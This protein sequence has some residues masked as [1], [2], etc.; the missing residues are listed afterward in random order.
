[1]ILA[2]FTTRQKGVAA[3][4]GLTLG[5]AFLAL[6]YRY[7]SSYYTAYQQLYSCF[8]IAFIISF[9]IFPQTLSWQ[10]LKQI[11]ARD[12]AIM[13]VRALVYYVLAINLYREA[14]TLTKIGNV[15]VMQAVPFTALFGMLFFKEKVTLAKAG[16][17][18]FA[19]IGVL[20]VVVKDVS[21][22]VFGRGEVLALIAAILFAFGY[23]FRKWQTTYLSDTEIT[24][25]ILGLST[26]F[27]IV[28][29]LF[30][31]GGLQGF[32]VAF[33]P[34]VILFVTAL[35][36]VVDIFFINYGFNNVPV[37]TANNILNLELVF[38]L[39]L[40]FIFYRE[41][42]TLLELGGCV[43][44]VTSAIALSMVNHT[45]IVGSSGGDENVQLFK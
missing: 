28:S 45:N 9:F 3:L 25:I 34:V 19:F 20:M 24:Q 6:T 18:I 38:A 26:V 10:K 35:L 14:L 42:P 12:W 16:L 22:S 2:N 44:I 27:L 31:D 30:F 13:I 32:T 4:V 36:Y 21:F 41:I 15:T 39:A 8:F 29:A 43:I 33:W 23:M 5:F 1:M 11:S 17:L 37:I 7:L 40:A